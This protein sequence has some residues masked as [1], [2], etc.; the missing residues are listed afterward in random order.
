MNR[1]ISRILFTAGIVALIALC[2][3]IGLSYLPLS[4]T[5]AQNS[6][7]SAKAIMQMGPITVIDARLS[8]TNS[9]SNW[10]TIMSGSMKTSEQKDMLM[11]ASLEVGLYTRTLVK[12]KSGTPDTSMASA[13]VEV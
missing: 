2:L 3:T 12:S 1:N 9:K 4:G 5:G 11:T 13:G 7:P 8:A 6:L 10:Q